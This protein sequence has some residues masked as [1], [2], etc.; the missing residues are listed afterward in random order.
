MWNKPS[1]VQSQI[2]NKISF[3]VFTN[4]F[5]K[6]LPLKIRPEASLILHLEKKWRPAYEDLV[7]LMFSPQRLLRTKRDTSFLYTENCIVRL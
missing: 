6:L 2:N 5:D 7:E 3:Q 4:M 1:S